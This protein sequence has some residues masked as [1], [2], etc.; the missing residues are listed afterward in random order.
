MV[1]VKTVGYTGW[2]IVSVIPKEN[3]Y[4]NRNE[5]NAVWMTVLAIAILMLIFVNQYLSSK[6]AQP[7]RRLEDSVKQLELE[8]PDKIYVGGSAEIQH[9]GKTIRSMAEQMRQ[10]MD[11]VVREQEQKRIYTPQPQSRRIY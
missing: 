7:L 2:K 1:V 3:L 11:D 5:I 4:R 8:F 10:L 9:L 6:I